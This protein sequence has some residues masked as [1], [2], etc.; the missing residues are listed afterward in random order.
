MLPL[1]GC[2]FRAPVFRVLRA[3]AKIVASGRRF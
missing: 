1:S 2:R 3:A